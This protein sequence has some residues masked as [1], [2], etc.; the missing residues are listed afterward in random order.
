MRRIAAPFV[1]GLLLLLAGTL[2]AQKKNFSYD[3][4]F[5]TPAALT[6]SKPLPIIRGWTDDE[7]YIEMQKEADGKTT[8]MLV[9]VK[10]GK[11]VAYTGT[12]PADPRTGFSTGEIP[13]T[14][15][16]KD[17]RNATA[18]P[19]GKW[20]A[21]TKKD[22]NL[23]VL[24]IAS[25]K[26]VQLT[27]DGSEHILNGY[28]SWVYYE[29]ILG[30]ASRYKAFWWSPD[31]K[32]ICYMRFDDSQVPVFPIYVID[33]QHGYLEEEHYPKA[34]DKNP[35]V[36]IGVVSVDNTTTTWADFNAKD[37][38]Y[39]GAPFWTPGGEL[40]VQWMNR[41][42]D[43]LKIYNVDLANGSKKEVYDEKQPTW[44]DLD[45][46]NRI[47]FFASGKGFI[48]KSDKDGWENL[49][50]Y[51]MAGKLLNQVTNGNFWSTSV[52]K[53]DE[54]AKTI[55]FRARKENSARFDFYKC[56]F[57]GK[58]LTRLSF[59]DY[60][61]DQ[62]S[63]SPNGK[64]FITN[65]SNLHTPA[66]TALVDMKGKVIRELG[67]SKG[68]DYDN[69]NIPKTE[70]VRVKSEDGL[71]DLPVTITYPVN[72]DPNKKY[73]I[74]VSVYG[75]PNAGTV[76]DRWRPVGGITQWWAQEGIIQVSFDNRSSGHF[77]KK[78]LNFIHRQL[79]KWEIEDYM[80]CARWLKK[81]SYVDGSKICI[82]GGSFGGYMTCMA[83]TYG[84]DVFTHGIANSSVTDWQF[85]DTHY[86]ERFMD[87]PQ[88]NPEGYK[89]T[90]VMAYADKYK[91]LLRIVHGTSDDNVHMQNSTTLIN[92]LQDLKKHFELMI[93][94]GERHGI[95]GLK[96]AHNRTEAYQFYYTNLL[97]RPMPA[98]FW[99]PS[100]QRG[101]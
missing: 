89:I 95:G 61:F 14:A 69:Y 79:G 82:T 19:D 21:Y 9:D 91:G 57:D 42:Q 54:K 31:S 18:S 11:A 6:V 52:V 30:R 44:I 47:E 25:Q 48:L 51:D 13:T 58:G 40:W 65:Y 77:G 72:F 76:Y 74:L 2:A 56:G 8:A 24:E 78:G 66:T 7:H 101:F 98:A 59:G 36:K 32:R 5:K 68:A 39:F 28:A 17:A 100:S 29:E 87:T 71:F 92:K 84:A 73:P 70:L 88:E 16:V 86:T 10:T 96:G 3:Q 33:G 15:Q 1:T 94:P 20:T 64:Y 62:V 49:Y 22:N 53:I 41:G 93:Y 85:Y 81:Q 35:E 67:N 60:T 45:E 80:T 75:G 27:K 97:N 55:Y 38:Q 26:E 4:L 46:G 12:V 99:E 37:D 43:N 23:Y 63:L 90:S 34:G 50:H 83:L